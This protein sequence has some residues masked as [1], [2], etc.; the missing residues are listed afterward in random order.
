MFGQAAHLLPAR[1]DKYGMHHYASVVRCHPFP[2]R[3][4]N[5]GQRAARISIGVRTEG[6]ADFDGF[7]PFS[8]PTGF[9]LHTQ[10]GHGRH[11]TIALPRFPQQKGRLPQVNQGSQG[12]LAVAILGNHSCYLYP[13]GHAPLV[14]SQITSDLWR[15]RPAVGNSQAHKR[16]QT[17]LDRRFCHPSHDA[18][19]ELPTRRMAR[20][21]CGMSK[22]VSGA[23]RNPQMR[24]PRRKARFLPAGTVTSRRKPN[25]RYLSPGGP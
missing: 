15:C 10:K 1:P 23:M 13:L 24:K 25:Q 17:Q 5:E 7:S 8:I 9:L 11:V 6:K 16:K 3:S 22:A 18:P 14:R 19:P 12:P 20:R 2:V 4:R 21:R